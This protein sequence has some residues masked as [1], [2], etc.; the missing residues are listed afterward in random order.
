MA[1]FPE[2]EAEFGK[3]KICLKCKSRNPKPVK[4]CRKCGYTKFRPK[5]KDTK[6]KR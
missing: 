6:K 4:K 1:K 2:A 3:V 5:K